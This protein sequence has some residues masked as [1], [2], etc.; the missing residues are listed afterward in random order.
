MQCEYSHSSVRTVKYSVRIVQLS[1]SKVV[2]ESTV[3]SNTLDVTGAR[4]REK[5]FS[6]RVQVYMVRVWFCDFLII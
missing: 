5:L 3:Q 2:V 6:V 4:V 1:A